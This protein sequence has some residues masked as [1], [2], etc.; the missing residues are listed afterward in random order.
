MNGSRPFTAKT[1]RRWLQTVAVA[2]ATPWP[3]SR[4]KA[5]DQLGPVRPPLAL[6]DVGVQGLDGKPIELHRL[7]RGHVTALQLMF[8]SCSATCPIQGAIFADTQQKLASAGPEMKLL[9]VSID[10]LGDDIRALQG[11]LARFGARPQRWTA[12]VPKIQDLDRLIEALRGRNGGQDRHT[13]QAF[14]FNRE[15]KLVYRSVDMPSGDE[16]VRLMRQIADMR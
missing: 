16:L 7:L 11:W 15:G 10:P 8:T 14:L 1:R 3:A 2:L 4:A 12:A 13:T 9:S 5:H 6:H